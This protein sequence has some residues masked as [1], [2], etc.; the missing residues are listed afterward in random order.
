MTEWQSHVQ[1]GLEKQRHDAVS[2]ACDRYT[3]NAQ[4]MKLL[5]CNDEPDSSSADANLAGACRSSLICA[6]HAAAMTVQCLALY[7]QQACTISCMGSE[8]C[9]FTAEPFYT[10]CCV[11]TFADWQRMVVLAFY[12]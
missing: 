12:F 1:L 9:K 3:E 7:Q 6:L 11:H 4:L 2:Q 8:C 5:C 10:C